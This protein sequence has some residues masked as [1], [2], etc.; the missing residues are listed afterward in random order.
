VELDDYPAQLAAVGR[1]HGEARS[2]LRSV[3]EERDYWIRSAHQHGGLSVRDIA[4]LVGMS[5]QRVGQIIQ[6]RG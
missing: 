5:H 4:G 3:E 1:R 6:A 2:A